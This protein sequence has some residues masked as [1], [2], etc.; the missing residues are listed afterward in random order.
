MK[1]LTLIL[2]LAIIHPAIGNAC[3]DPTITP[4]YELETD[5]LDCE[6]TSSGELICAHPGPFVFQVQLGEW[7]CIERVYAIEQGDGFVLL[8]QY[9]DSETGASVALK[10]SPAGALLWNTR[11]GGFNVGKP[12]VEKDTAFVTAIGMVG[13]LDLSTGNWAWRHEGLYR[14]FSFGSSIGTPRRV[15]AGILFREGPAPGQKIQREILVNPETGEIRHNIDPAE[16]S[17]IER[18]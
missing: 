9:G 13:R 1:I 4:L 6:L 11:I 2:V 16:Q 7:D 8:L 15:D 14:A 12:L 10:L 5:N 3:T 17:V 18:Q